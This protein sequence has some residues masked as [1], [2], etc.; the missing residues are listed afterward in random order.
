LEN[1]RE[2]FC[3]NEYPASFTGAEAVVIEK[4]KVYGECIS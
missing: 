3:A 1:V 2:L 4:N